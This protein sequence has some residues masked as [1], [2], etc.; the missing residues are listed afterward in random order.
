MGAANAR[1]LAHLLC[2]AEAAARLERAAAEESAEAAERLLRAAAEEGSLRLAA[3]L[4]EVEDQGQLER[5]GSGRAG[6]ELSRQLEKQE[7][8]ES[9]ALRNEQAAERLSRSSAEEGS[10]RLA[11]QLQEAEDKAQRE[12]GL[13]NSLELARKLDKQERQLAPSGK[14]RSDFCSRQVW[15]QLTPCERAAMRYVDNVA[16][17]NHVAALPA[18][19]ARVQALGF[20]ENDLH[21]CL[22]YIDR[23]SVV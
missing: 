5:A 8:Q 13:K 17:L 10:R 16:H 3:Q 21:A 2:N 6:R 18:L 15:K 19:L 12:A 22:A 11:A 1:A 23:K 4:Q 7:R 20:Q 14:K 9:R